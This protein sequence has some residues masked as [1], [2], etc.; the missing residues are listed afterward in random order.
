MQYS[1]MCYGSEHAGH[2]L[3]QAEDDK[4]MAELKAIQSN[5]PGKIKLRAGVRL[6]P[7]TAATTVHY[8][9][10]TMVIDGPFA[11]TKEQLLGF[12]VIDCDSLEDAIEATHLLI[13]PRVDAGLIGS[14][15]IRPIMMADL[16]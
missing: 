7:T 11:E 14:L 3:S 5:F 10:N 13:G 16:E 9:R 1:V 8:G 4:M 15:E 12:Y 2:A 6:M